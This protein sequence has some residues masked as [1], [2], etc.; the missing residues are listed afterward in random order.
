MGL[1]HPRGPQEDHVLVI[2]DE[3]QV[4]KAH[5]LLFVQFGMERELVLLDGLGRG[6]PGG[7]HRGLNAALLFGAHF[8]FQQV[9]Q[10]RQVGAFVVLGLL[11][12]VLEHFGGLGEL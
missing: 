8:F 2:G 4:E 9:V 11:K 10:K 7:L 1:A 3:V 5:H 6:K 12:D